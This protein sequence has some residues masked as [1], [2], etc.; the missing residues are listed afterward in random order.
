MHER[1]K[2]LTTVKVLF[3]DDDAPDEEPER[4]WE[5]DDMAILPL[6]NTLAL[7][8]AK[9]W[10][11]KQDYHALAD[12][13]AV[14]GEKVTL[15]MQKEEGER[16]QLTADSF[17]PIAAAGMVTGVDQNGFITLEVQNRI[18]IEEIVQLPDGSFSMSV[19]RRPDSG[20]LA[21]EEASRGLAT[22]KSRILTFSEGQQ[23][24][25]FIRSFSL[26]WDNI[27]TV[28]GVMSP[29]LRI[30]AE[31]RYAM[32]AED[33]IGARFSAVEKAILIHLGFPK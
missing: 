1:N 29:W 12:R 25:G 9:I 2:T 17:F 31:E 7:P 33:D 6:Y 16:D 10:M 24:E 8:G 18:N 14:T 22:V 30:S 28:A 15:L 20:E 13:D 21:P 27:W 32:L 11:R 19:S 5:D 26:Y 4:T 23:W 3:Y